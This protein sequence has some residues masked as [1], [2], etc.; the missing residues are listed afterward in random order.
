MEID[1]TSYQ[2]ALMVHLLWMTSFLALSQI[3][4]WQTSYGLLFLLMIHL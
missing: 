3:V 1:P 2:L 4:L